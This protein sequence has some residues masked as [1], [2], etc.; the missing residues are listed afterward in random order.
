MT[1]RPN[2]LFVNGILGFLICI[3]T[4]GQIL[5]QEAQ[6][7]V[8]LLGTVVSSKGGVALLKNLSS[9]QVKAFRIGEAVWELGTLGSVQRE[10]VSLK[11]PG[12]QVETVSSKLRSLPKSVVKVSTEDKHIED[13]FSRI[14][15]KTEVDARY[16][17]RMLKEELP[18]ILMQASSEAVLEGGEIKGFRLFQFEP[19]SIFA[20]L[21][22][23]E[24][25]VVKEI[26]GVPLNNV[27]RTIQ[28]LNGLR[29]EPNVSVTIERNGAPVSLDLNVK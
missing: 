26:N 12:G 11:R 21:G 16:R 23:K 19:N 5:G 13:G 9:G 28:F 2:T 20:K 10:I 6:R 22:I 17:D 18:N 29:S 4:F 3:F 24:G 7:Q 8:Q 27:A 1:H 15:N 25:D 14:G